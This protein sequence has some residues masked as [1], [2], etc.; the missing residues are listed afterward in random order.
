M[1]K[2]GSARSREDESTL[3]FHARKFRD[4]TF[5]DDRR[6]KKLQAHESTSDDQAD[7][8]AVQLEVLR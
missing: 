3:H 6:K 2:E 1:P 8:G 7:T 4:L 5:T